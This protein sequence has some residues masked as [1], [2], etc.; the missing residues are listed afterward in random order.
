[1]LCTHQKSYKLD[2][3]IILFFVS[4]KNRPLLLAKVVQ[5]HDMV[6]FLRY[7]QCVSWLAR[8]GMYELSLL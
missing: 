5:P 3:G 2:E 7:S 4:E 1:M 8:M 6:I